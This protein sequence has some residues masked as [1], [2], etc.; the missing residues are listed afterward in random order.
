M[1]NGLQRCPGCGATTPAVDGPTHP[2]LGASA[3]CLAAAGEVLAREYEDYARYAPVH[4][5]GVSAYPAQHPGVPSPR[6]TASVGV[7]LI[8][9]HLLLERGLRPENAN[10]AIVWASRRKGDFVWLDPP[11][12]LGDLTVLHVRDSR[13]PEEHIRRV[14]EWAR[15]VWGAWSPHH[16]TIRRWAAS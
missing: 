10:A 2:Y 6:A 13:D 12:S 3:G 11:S 7:H 1:T 5:L 8:R 16:E 14:G 4:R 9:L 15:S